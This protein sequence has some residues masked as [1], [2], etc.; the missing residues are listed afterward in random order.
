[1]P[2]SNDYSMDP[3]LISGESSNSTD[4]T[5]GGVVPKVATTPISKPVAA[6]KPSPFYQQKDFR[7]EKL[8]ALKGLM[9]ER[10]AGRVI[11]RYMKS[12]A[13]QRAAL[14]FARAENQKHMASVDAYLQAGMNRR[15]TMWKPVISQTITQEPTLVSKST[16]QTTQPA[17]KSTTVQQKSTPVQP[18]QVGGIDWDQRARDY[19][20]KDQAEVAKWQATQP[21]LAVDGKFGDKSLARWQALQ[22]AAQQESQQGQTKAIDM[23][24]SSIHGMEIPVDNQKAQPV[25]TQTEQPAIKQ[26]SGYTPRA[27]TLQDFNTHKNFRNPYHGHRTIT[28]D[29]KVYPVRVTTGLYGRYGIDNDQMYAFDEATGMIRKVDENMIGFPS[30]QGFAKDSQWV[31][32]RF[33]YKEQWLQQNPAPAKRGPLGGDWTPE[34]KKWF[35]EVYEPAEKAGFRKQGGTMNRINYFQQ[36]GAAPK[37]DIRAQIAALVQ[38][39]MQGDEKANQQ[40]TQ[41]MEAAKAGNQQAVQLAQMITEVAK[42]LQGQ[43]TAAK[44]GAKLNYIQS[45]K[46]AKGGK[47]CP[48][49]KK[50]VETKACGGKKAKKHQEGGWLELL[51]IY[52]TY[53]AGK[54]FYKNP[55]WRTAGEFGLNFLGDAAML[56]GVGLGAKA[57]VTGIRA[58]AMAGKAG[59]AG[60]ATMQGLKTAR[61][62]A[63]AQKVFGRTSDAAARTFVK[64]GF[65]VA[66]PAYTNFKVTDD[67]YRDVVRRGLREDRIADTYLDATRAAKAATGAGAAGMVAKVGAL[68]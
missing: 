24:Y 66:R 17:Q 64:T 55:S 22:Q 65:P 62:V 44:W 31:H 45:L 2:G 25:V 16:A 68:E 58:A 57:A 46:F 5:S 1:M 13:G 28:V 7:K 37:Q 47:T 27:F 39:A 41:I 51:P 30:G 15:A 49:C 8:E 54:R 6:A 20:F 53:Q 19:G 36:G 11:D 10:R 60:K 21:G 63:R 61:E 3:E 56:S 18:K 38:A 43:A 4:G 23:P 9:S 29:G 14:D 34:Y 12:E 67:I 26:T 42:Q 52:G 32:P 50:K 35:S 48:A 40:V 59:K 33:F